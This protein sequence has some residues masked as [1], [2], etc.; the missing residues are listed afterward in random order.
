MLPA[1]LPAV[2]ARFQEVFRQMVRGAPAAWPLS[3]EARAAEAA[4]A[5]LELHGMAPLVFDG[6]DPLDHS[7]PAPALIS[8]R[9]SALRA[10]AAEPLRQHDLDQVLLGFRQAGI[11]VMVIKGSALARQIYS[12]P[13]LRP[14]AD[15]DLLVRSSDGAGARSLLASLG[16]SGRLLSGDPLA[17]RQQAFDRVDSFGVEHVYDLHWDVT[18]TP[19]VRHALSF[20]ELFARSV[21]VGLAQ[22]PSLPDALLLACIHR[23]AHHHDSERLIWLLDIYLLHERL[24]REERGLFQRECAARGISA[25]C[26]RSVLLAEER[27]SSISD[28][29]MAWYEETLQRREPSAKFLERDRRQA[30]VLKEDLLAL[31]WMDRLQRLR[32]LAL[33]P[34]AFMRSRY[35][36]APASALPFLYVARGVRGVARLFRRVHRA[37]GA[38]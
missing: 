15:T 36:S 1:D 30:S 24:S 10:A 33:P 18:N 34:V 16:Y 8:L 22:V 38:P 13:E 28:A 27:F 3:L 14:R 25:I 11:D 21:R 32:D 5:A 6:V 12:R 29:T 20:D 23:A 19:V 4:V 2:P 26:A 35:P 37:G 17:N 7:W 9:A 31:G